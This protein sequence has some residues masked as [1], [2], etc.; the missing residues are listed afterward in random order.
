M[1]NQAK[2]AYEL[3][4]SSQ[5]SAGQKLNILTYLFKTKVL[6][7][8]IIRSVEIIHTLNCNCRC[9]FC[10]NDKLSEQISLMKKEDVFRTIDKLAA[11]GVVSIIFLGGESL[12]D[13]N[14]IDYIKHTKAKNIVPRLQTNG[15]MLTEEKISELSNAGL[16]DVTITMHDT[17]PEN[18]N[19]TFH[20]EGAFDIAAKALPILKRLGIKIYLKAIYS[21]E[22][23]ASGALDRI[24]SMAKEKG[25]KLNVNPFMPVGK[26]VKDE[27]LLSP[28]EKESYTTLMLSE[29][30]ITTHTKNKYDNQCPAGH[31]Y[32]GI[33]PDGEVLP[34]YFLP[35]S[36]GNIKD[37]DIKTAQQKAAEMKIFK[38]G[39]NSCIVAM[40]KKFYDIVIKEIYSGKYVLPIQIDKHPEIKELLKRYLV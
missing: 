36:V 29:D 17:I 38:K 26:G 21:R 35:I 23:V 5:L 7:Q 31:L 24:L 8:D 27:N 22:T 11:H 14:L 10:S 28:E 25:L 9:D 37:I 40:D 18:H 3:L 12:T 4:S 1:F 13:P 2:T 15:T 19:N 20:L 32:L 34:C 16:Y 6:K 39:N 33:L 30:T